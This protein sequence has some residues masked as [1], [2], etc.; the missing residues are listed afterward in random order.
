MCHDINTNYKLIPYRYILI[1]YLKLQKLFIYM[2]ILITYM[3]HKY[4]YIFI[5][6]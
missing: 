2:S 6:M 1:L 3:K 4:F 5:Y